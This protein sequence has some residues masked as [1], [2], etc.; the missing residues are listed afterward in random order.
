LYIV[1]LS[2]L[3]PVRASNLIRDNEPPQGETDTTS[4]AQDSKVHAGTGQSG[5]RKKNRKTTSPDLTGTWYFEISN[6]EHRGYVKLK[7]SGT[8]ITGTWHTTSKQEDDTPVIGT[9]NGNRVALRRSKVWGSHDQTFDLEILHGGIQLYGY[10]EGFFLNH[11]DLNM[12]RV[13]EPR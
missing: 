12:R 7:Q 3:G 8:L 13:E 11:S 9:V 10:G 6:N 5:S 4:K 1:S 2:T